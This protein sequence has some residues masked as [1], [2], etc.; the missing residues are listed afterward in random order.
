MNCGDNNTY[1]WS[2]Y[3][4][5]NQNDPF[6]AYG[7]GK[8]GSDVNSLTEVKFNWSTLT[9]RPL[10]NI[11]KDEATGMVTFDYLKDFASTGISKT[12]INIT[13]KRP[14]EYYDMEG[15]KVKNPIKGHLYITNKGYKMIF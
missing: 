5:S 12:I 7:I 15:R 8:D 1:T 14:T 10:Y 3:D 6:P 11:K 13:D 4:T 2:D 9:S